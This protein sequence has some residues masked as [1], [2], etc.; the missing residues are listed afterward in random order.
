MTY[1]DCCLPMRLSMCIRTSTERRI[2]HNSSHITHHSSP[3]LAPH[4]PRT[5]RTPRTSCRTQSYME[6]LSAHAM[7]TRAP[8][9]RDAHPTFELK[10]HRRRLLAGAAGL[11]C[12]LV[13]SLV[14]HVVVVLQLEHQPLRHLRTRRQRMAGARGRWRRQWRGAGAVRPLGKRVCARGRDPPASWRWG[15]GG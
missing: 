15:A 7:R 14:A 11:L 8:A 4:N 3:H 1:L 12:S 5:T 10:R 13:T 2:A 9:R 6:S